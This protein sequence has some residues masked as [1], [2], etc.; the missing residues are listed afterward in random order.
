MTERG[1]RMR[2]VRI[3]GRFDDVLVNVAQVESVAPYAPETLSSPYRTELRMVSG[4]TVKST[5]CLSDVVCRLLYS[6]TG[7]VQ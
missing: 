5:E 7:D 4:A 1:A 3:P 6:S 2:F